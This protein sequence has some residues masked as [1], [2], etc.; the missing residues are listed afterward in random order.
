MMA[1]LAVHYSL[2]DA[3]E[4]S[5]NGGIFTDISTA[6]S[7]PCIILPQPPRRKVQSC[8][9]SHGHPASTALDLFDTACGTKPE[10]LIDYAKVMKP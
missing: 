5:H 10:R 2:L 1:E 4:I 7:K 8:F 9:A 6:P 3:L